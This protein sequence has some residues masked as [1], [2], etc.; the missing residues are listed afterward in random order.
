MLQ[1]QSKRG[2]VIK[3]LVIIGLWTVVT[4]LISSITILT[5][6]QEGSDI[7]FWGIVWFEIICISPWIVLTPAVIWLARNYKLDS[8]H[9]YTTIGVHLAAMLLVFSI[10]SVVQS[11]AVSVFYEVAFTWAYIQRDFLGFIDMRVMLYA[12]ILLGVYALDFQRKNREIELKEPR[13]KA[14]LNQAKFHALI[15]Q[16][17]PDFLMETIDAIKSSLDKGEEESEE[18]LTEFS[19]L[20][21]IMLTNVNKD[22]VVLENDLEAFRLYC[23]IVKKRL[24]Q[25]ITIEENIEERC[26]EVLVPS[27]LILIPVFEQI[28]DSIKPGVNIMQKIS[29]NAKMEDG[30]LFLEVSIQGEKLPYKEVPNYLRNTE[31]LK[32]VDKYQNRYQNVDFKTQTDENLITINLVFPYLPTE[33]EEMEAM[34]DS[35]I[36]T[37]SYSLRP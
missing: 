17:Q 34:A 27:F 36:T 37:D 16:I 21:R 1:S 30:N 20:L 10:H 18:I 32:I 25:D 3:V 19:D 29:Y 9:I 13:L 4:L 26:K 33:E 24:G 14:E 28:I 5:I 22:E 23:K 6:L 8:E 7:D 12:G 15:N 11:Y 35:A 31:I 2:L